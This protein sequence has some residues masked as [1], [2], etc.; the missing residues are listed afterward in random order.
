MK[1]I[2]IQAHCYRVPGYDL[3][4]IKQEAF[5]ICAS[6]LDRWDGERPL[7]NFLA[8]NLSNR[9]KSFVRDKL[10]LQ[11]SLAK[12][13]KLVNEAIEIE[14][15]NWDTEKSLIEADNVIEEVLENDFYTTLDKY[16]PI[17][18]RKD[19]LKMKAG[20]K[21]NRGRA[22]QVRQ[23]LEQLFKELEGDQWEK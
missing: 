9:L 2:E 3:E 17:S 15:V 20:V 7:E 22:K 12:A 14:S 18:L 4:D 23:Y 16:I 10:K 8:F 21:V 5:I 1:V 19:Y 13:N 11:G 6:A